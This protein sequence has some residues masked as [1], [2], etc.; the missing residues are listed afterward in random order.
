[1][2]VQGQETAGGG[3]DRARGAVNS[4]GHDLVSRDAR[5]RIHRDDAGGFLAG[6]ADLARTRAA[7]AEIGAA[8]SV[9]LV[10]RGPVLA[11]SRGVVA[12]RGERSGPTPLDAPALI[13]L[14]SDLDGLCAA[15][16]AVQ[17]R[18]VV[19][20]EVAVRADQAE[21]D[22][23]DVPPASPDGA[24]RPD[25][26]SRIAAREASIALR[27]SPAGATRLLGTSRRLVRD[28][29]R[30]LAHLAH[31][32]VGT[33]VAHAVSRAAGPVDAGLRGAID[34]ALSAALPHL[35]GAGIRQWQGEVDL[36]AHQLHPEGARDR[37]ERARRERGVTLRRRA[38]GMA[39][40]SI[41][42]SGI[43]AALVRKR[44]SLEAE[45]LTVLG[46]RR[47]HQQIMAD[48]LVDTV[49]GRSEELDPVTL[50]IGIIVTD[51]S[52]L[53]P[54][55]GDAATV[56][57]YGV[58]PFSA[59]RTCLQDALRAPE[60]G[61]EDPLG[62]DGPAVRAVY[63]RLWTH[64]TTAELVAVESKAR[65]FPAALR[66]AVLWR[67]GTCRGP[68]CDADI[69]QVDH[70]RAHAAGGAT[71]WDNANGL[72]AAC[73][74]K[75]TFTRGVVVE[76]RVRWM[77]RYGQEAGR[78]AMSL[79]VR[80]SAMGR[81]VDPGEVEQVHGGMSQDVEDLD[82]VLQD[83]IPLAGRTSAALD[84]EHGLAPSDTGPIGRRTHVAE[85]TAGISEVAD[86]IAA[87]AAAAGG[88]GVP[89]SGRQ[90]VTYPGRPGG[91]GR[92]DL[93]WPARPDVTALWCGPLDPGEMARRP[94][95][96]RR[97]D[98]PGRRARH[99]SRRR[100]PG[101]RND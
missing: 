99:R 91:F 67:D 92:V 36:L 69:R 4:H 94:A 2:A 39:T 97:G 45:R 82:E 30:M 89:P 58:V 86:R 95:R 88:G 98:R 37:H 59:V 40:I 14:L 54:E 35:D 70:V 13:D 34:A 48:R 62:A 21:N 27:R 93:V 100:G 25:I 74:Q 83:E 78:G 49:I 73:N 16:A 17:A 43:D 52:L 24:A 87:P 56:E 33:E 57:G 46:D 50:D 75:E 80:R 55:D 42:T 96:I 65:A 71:S 20:L 8:G 84:P 23:A 3:G 15:I 26:A 32:D 51:R 79:V 77:T 61:T 12:S 101:K 7:L 38:H 85:V 9:D 63:R 66:R 10:D 72:C 60:P 31:G 5:P 53:G 41:T 22:A 68:Y 28:L 64:P 18:A 11:S 29:P 6:G 44:L 76:R 47:G 19:A 90:E 1:M 81:G